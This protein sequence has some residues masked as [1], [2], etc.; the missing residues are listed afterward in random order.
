MKTVGVTGGIGSGKSI[1]CQV[2]E[3][4]GFP[5]FYSDAEAKKCMH[6]D[7]ELK[8]AIQQH[9]GKEAYENDMLN[10][11]YLAKIIFSDSSKKE[12][13]N[14]LVHPAVYRAFEAWKKIQT[15][16]ILFNESALLF[17]TGSFKR[18]DATILVTADPEIRIQRVMKRDSISRE[19]VLERM[20]N[21]WN[22]EQKKSF[23][24]FVI[25]NN[26]TELILPQLN[27]ILKKLLTNS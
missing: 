27:L 19:L 5:V 18:F 23:S 24:T 9:F 2:L 20:N 22:D 17:E 8:Q 26:P 14:Q 3:T 15:A 12:I 1:V 25:S 4:M 6:T 13:L 21:Q 11:T 16:P 7:P 10:R